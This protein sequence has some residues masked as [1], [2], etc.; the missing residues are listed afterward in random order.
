MFVY[1]R[2]HFFLKQNMKQLIEQTEYMEI[3]YE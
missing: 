2:V 1:Q 3:P